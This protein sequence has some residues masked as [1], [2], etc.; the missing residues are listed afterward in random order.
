MIDMV[1]IYY[2]DKFCFYKTKKEIYM[3][4]LCWLG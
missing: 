3:L 4:M 2:M 1:P